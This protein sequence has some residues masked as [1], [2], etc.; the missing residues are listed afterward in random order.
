[1]QPHP[2]WRFARS[3][4]RSIGGFAFSLGLIIALLRLTGDTTYAVE[5]QTS[6]KH[7]VFT[8]PCATPSYPAPAPTR[9]PAIDSQCGPAGS[10]TGPE[11]VQNTSKNDFCAKGTARAIT[12]DYLT[13]LQKQVEA[14]PAINFGSD[15]KGGRTRG[16]TTNRAPLTK[17]GEGNLVTLKAFVLIARQEGAESVN[18]EKNV[19]DTSQFHDI[20]ISLVAAKSI[21]DECAGVVAEMSPHHR[22]D[23][24]TQENVA[25]V[26]SAHLPVRVTG[27]LYF[28][29]SHFP[30]ANDK[31]AG[32]G[33]PK[34]VSLWEIHPIYK[35]EVCTANCDGAGTWVALDQWVKKQK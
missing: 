26:A 29:S 1:M 31:T 22:P 7:A 4:V 8:L 9:S 27:H 28:D 10:G 14:N 34:R 16:P 30:C 2:N 24:W 6:A 18:C 5:K 12:I 32:E 21:T 20:H 23:S 33:N 35:F 17:L 3:I 13:S 25:K 15:D 19:P 11:G